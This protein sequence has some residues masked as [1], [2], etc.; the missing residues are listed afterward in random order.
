MILDSLPTVKAG[1]AIKAEH[2]NAL[3]KA[4]KRRTP[5]ASETVAVNATSNGFT[6]SASGGGRS[7]SSS[8][9]RGCWA[10]TIKGAKG[11]RKISFTSGYI[12]DG[13][14]I[15]LPEL[16]DITCPDS[17]DVLYYVCLYVTFT[18]TV[19]DGYVTGGTIDSASIVIDS[20][21]PINTDSD[22]NIL[23]CTIKNG[24]VVDRHSWWSLGINLLAKDSS[25]GVYFRYYAAS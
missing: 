9:F 5:R 22:G 14:Y 17:T 25:S 3:V 19:V 2:Y 8:S 10:P 16:D 21:L 13:I 12:T 6:L 20:S 18:P 4:I 24:A 1:D 11:E 23:L 15:V 7:G